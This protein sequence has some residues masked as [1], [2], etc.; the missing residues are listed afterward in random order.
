MSAL[1]TMIAAAVA[2]APAIMSTTGM[3]LSLT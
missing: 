2:T 3:T 1:R